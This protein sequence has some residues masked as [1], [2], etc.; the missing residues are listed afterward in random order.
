MPLSISEAT[1][2]QLASS[3]RKY[4]GK[5][6]ARAFSSE[7]SGLAFVALDDD[8]VVGWCWGYDLVRPDGNRMIYI[9]EI[10]VDPGLRRRGL[11]RR[12]IGEVLDRAAS[13]GAV[14]VFVITEKTNPA[15]CGLYEATGAR[16]AADG[17]SVLYWWPPSEGA[18]EAHHIT[19]DKTP[20]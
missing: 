16:R 14:K 6:G 3:V 17:E 19:D 8:E 18:G 9:H 11:G 15:A 13:V 10:E 12:M 4:K 7:R 5:D 2:D 20:Q 1:V